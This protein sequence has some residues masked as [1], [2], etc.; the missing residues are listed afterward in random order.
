MPSGDVMFLFLGSLIVLD[1][2]YVFGDSGHFD[3]FGW[4]LLMLWLL[5]ILRLKGF[6]GGVW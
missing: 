2:T 6:D 1:W 5:R 3:W 4:L